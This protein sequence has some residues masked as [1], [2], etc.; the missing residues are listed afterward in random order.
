MKHQPIP[1]PPFASSAPTPAPAKT[2]HPMC[3]R[4]R[5]PVVSGTYQSVTAAQGSRAGCG[6]PATLRVP[7]SNRAV[8]P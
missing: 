5:R 3:M 1:R 6:S 7:L 8:A 4:H 2:I